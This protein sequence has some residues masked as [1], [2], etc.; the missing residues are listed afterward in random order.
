M[1]RILLVFLDGVGLGDP[2]P[3]T[4]P[5]AAATTPTLNQLAGGHRWLRNTGRQNSVR[6]LF[7]PT[8]PRLGMAGLPQSGTGQATILTGC[9]VPALVGQHY[10][11]KPDPVTRQLLAQDNFFKQVVNH[12]GTAALIEAYPPRWHAAINSGK[13]LRASY[14]QAA[15][16]AGLTIFDEVALYRGDA[17]AVDWTGEAW[18]S[19]LGYSDS[20]VYT[21]AEAGAKMVEIARRYDFAFFSHW[22]TDVIGHRGTMT[23]AVELLKLFD[24]VMAGALQ[25]WN[26]DEGLI[27]ITSD[28]GNFEDLSHRHHTANDVPTVIIGRDRDVFADGYSDLTGLASRMAR[29]L[30]G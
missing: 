21:P 8:D 23:D 17:L 1:A 10:G 3:D 18:R 25:A 16:E 30:F 7:I 27:I 14:Q 13:R 20:P 26:D 19:Q 9:N 6:S 29:Y 11:P 4:N 12:G 5:F 22:L 2:N 15:H 24:A 28:H